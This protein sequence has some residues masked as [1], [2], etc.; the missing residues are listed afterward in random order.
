MPFVYVYALGCGWV[1]LYSIYKLLCLEFNGMIPGRNSTANS[2]GGTRPN[3]MTE[4]S[5]IQACNNSISH[6]ELAKYARMG[7]T[8]KTIWLFN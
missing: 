4:S 6:N 7:C 5:C 1:L 3:Y 8:A 2:V